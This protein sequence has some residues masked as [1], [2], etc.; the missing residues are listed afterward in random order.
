MELSELWFL[1]I[2]VLWIGFVFLEGFDFGVGMG[3]KFL[4]KGETERRV[5]INTIGPHWDANEVW[6]LT[7]GGAMF[8]AFPHWYATLFSGY[9][10]AFVLLLLALI[11][12]GVSFEY[13]SKHDEKKWKGTWDW[14]IFLGSLLPPFLVGVLFSGLIKGLPIDADMNMHASFFGDIV[15]VYT[16]VGGV[17]FAALCYLHGLNFI[18]MKTEGEL[19]ERART[20]ALKIYWFTGVLILLFVALTGMYTNA[21]T[22]HA[23]INITIYALVIVVYLALYPL[24]KGKKEG[25]SFTSTG[26]VLILVTA[27]IFTIL[28]PNVMISTT[29]IANNITIY[30]AASGAYSLKVMTIV[31]LTMV[32]IVLAYTIWS[33]YVFRKRVSHKEHLEY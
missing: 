5:L 31:A 27:S 2:A 19:R 12:R 1:L 15:N 26:L 21:F 16:L 13:R 23:V 33:Y 11:A 10:L 6:L 20:Q 22:K 30:E 14:A 8:A 7:A 24:I 25:L 32:P 3:V 9:Y 28:F 17:T 4:A 18:T 29:D